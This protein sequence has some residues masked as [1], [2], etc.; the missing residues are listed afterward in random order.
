[1][2]KPPRRP[3]REITQPF[4]DGIVII[5]SVENG[6]APG[7]RPVPMLLE[8]L[9]LRYQER[10]LGVN[11]LYSGRQNQVDIQRIIRVQ[12]VSGLSSQDVV[13]AEDGEQYRVDSV[14]TVTDVYPPCLDLTLAAVKRKYEVKL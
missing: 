6:A 13:I 9:R 1:M 4:N 7:M 14:Q 11:R 5:Y 8:K 12:K 10:Y 2:W 3:S